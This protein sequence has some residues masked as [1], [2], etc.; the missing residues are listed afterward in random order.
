M[1][2]IPTITTTIGITMRVGM[3]HIPMAPIIRS[4]PIIRPIRIITPRRNP[5][6]RRDSWAAANL[7]TKLKTA[8]DEKKIT[9]HA[10]TL[11]QVGEWP[12]EA[13]TFAVANSGCTHA[14]VVALRLAE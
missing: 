9:H 11:A 5:S 3:S 12:K 14:S 13:A 10:P 8:N 1:P 2:T 7:H 4:T 6:S